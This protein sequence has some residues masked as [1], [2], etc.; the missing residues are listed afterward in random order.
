MK[1]PKPCAL[2]VGVSTAAKVLGVSSTSLLVS[3]PVALSARSAVLATPPA[4]IAVPL[5]APEMTA[6]SLVPLMAIVKG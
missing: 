4:S 1:V 6:A 2:S 3:V 5:M